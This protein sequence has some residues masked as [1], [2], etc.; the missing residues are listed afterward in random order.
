MAKKQADDI[1]GPTIFLP[2]ATLG[3]I[4]AELKSRPNATYLFVYID[5]DEAAIAENTR[6]SRLELAQI[7]TQQAAKLLQQHFDKDK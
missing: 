5:G 6:Y 7:F 2:W 1:D 4:A 3:Q